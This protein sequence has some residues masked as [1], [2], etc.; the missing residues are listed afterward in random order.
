MKLSETNDSS[1][2][3][4]IDI[5]TPRHLPVTKMTFVAPKPKPT[6]WR[7]VV[8]YAGRCAAFLIAVL[9]IGHLLYNPD[10]TLAADKVITQGLSTMRSSK[11]C[12]VEFMAR[13]KPPT[14]NR[15][16][17]MSPAGK[18][19]NALLIY[20]SEP[21]SA[22]IA[23]QWMLAGTPYGLRI[24]PDGNVSC[25]GTDA[26]NIGKTSFFSNFANMLYYDSSRYRA[27]L[28]DDMVVKRTDGNIVVEGSIKNDSV[29]FIAVF[30]ANSNRLTS[31]KLFDTSVSPSLLMLE[32]KSIVYSD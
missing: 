18:M 14:P 2:S 28:G 20:S 12:R 15:F 19:T 27:I 22:V 25:D 10:A 26:V 31:L 32:T 30:A 13:M 8:T 3:Q 4:V 5:L 11:M 16:F 29:G 7:R 1:Y 6:R 21:D 23:L 9:F 24:S 17:R